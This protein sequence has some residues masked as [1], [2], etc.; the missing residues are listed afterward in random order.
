MPKPRQGTMPRA[1]N[2]RNL[3]DEFYWRCK[4]R[5]ANRRQSLQ[6][7]IVGVVEQAI[8]AAERDASKRTNY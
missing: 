7:F 8:T 3:P 6:D 1:I 5:A 2:L 4:E